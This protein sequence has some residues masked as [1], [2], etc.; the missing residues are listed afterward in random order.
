VIT[1]VARLVEVITVGTPY[2]GV[3]AELQ[4]TELPEPV[5]TR[6][7]E[8]AS[9]AI[10][11][12]PSADVPSPLRRLARFT[13][14]KRARLGARPLLAEL[15][16]SA[17]FRAAVLAWWAEQRPG[18]LT[19]SE[20]DPV[21]G[22]AGAVLSG[23]PDV[24]DRLAEIAERADLATLRIQRDAALAKVDKLSAELDRLR[25]ELAEARA[26]IREAHQTRDGE[27]DRLR[28][29]IR[30]QGM[31]V[32]RAE[33]ATSAAER[34][35]AQARDGSAAQ[36]AAALVE[37][38]RARERADA[39]RIRAARA[40]EQASGARQAAREARRADEV[41]LE[42]LM[43]TLS[44]AVA[45]LRHELALDRYGQA[46]GPRPADLV[47]SASSIRSASARVPDAAALDRLLAL[48]SAHLIVDG[49]NISKTEYPELTLFDQR[50]RLVGGLAAL[51][52]R[53]GAEVTVVFDG[54]A[55][56]VPGLTRHPKGVRVLF[57]EP[58]VLADDVIRDLVAAEPAGRLV[59]V[60]SSDRA[61]ADSVQRDGAHPMAALILLDLLKRF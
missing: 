16:E 8:V 32:R 22:A 20:A 39:E 61:V 9:L 55:V 26:A 21:A 17:I 36:L 10:G 5:R 29:R 54:A 60:A 40:A 37:R 12:L 15:R 34:E 41:R 6:L 45:G 52:A 19:G 48:P 11:E 58:G 27:L 47:S 53:T 18:E 43:D 44:S 23:A 49:Y 42:L 56:T 4:W 38:D 57:S 3:M 30:E 25:A 13:P 24:A 1:R 51:V 31:R 46:G 50:A 2:P 7:A 33:D 28:R 35:L 59:V 14:S